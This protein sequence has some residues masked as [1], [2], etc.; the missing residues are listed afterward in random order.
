LKGLDED[1]GTRS[2][3]ERLQE[4]LGN[5]EDVTGKEDLVTYLRMQVLQKVLKPHKRR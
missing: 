2:P 3:E 1:V 5:V 4:V